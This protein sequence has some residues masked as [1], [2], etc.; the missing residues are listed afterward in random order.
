VFLAPVVAVMLNGCFLHSAEV[1][2]VH[3]LLR[4][5]VPAAVAQL[6]PV[7]PAHY[8]DKE[9]NDRPGKASFLSL[10]W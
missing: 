7:A 2:K 1:Q 5:V 6:L 4:E 10:L 9:I 3:R 8:K